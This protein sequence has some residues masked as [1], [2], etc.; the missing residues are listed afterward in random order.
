MLKRGVFKSVFQT[1][2]TMITGRGRIDEELF[3]AFEEALLAADVSVRTADRVLA[4]LRAYVRDNRL[5]DGEQVRSRFKQSLVAA[6]GEPG[7]T[8][9]RFA[10]TSPSLF[11]MVGVNGVGKTTTLGKLAHQ[12]VQEGKK[13]IL[14]AG[15]TFRAAAA[16]QLAIW[17][18]RAGADFI[19]QHERSDPAAVVFDAVQAAKSRG[20]DLIL[21]DTAGRL[22]TKNNLMEELRKIGRVSERELG[23]KPDEILLAL[24]A[25]TGQ[26]AIRQAKEFISAVGVTGIALAKLDGTARGGIV[27]TIREELGLPIKLVG[28]GEGIDDLLPFDPELFVE[29]MLSTE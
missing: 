15:D 3:E 18:E 27:I 6:L 10:D 16:D 29:A 5:I 17:A 25:T 13:V 19:R 7:E 8:A 9:L 2:D 4:D 26:N 23:R 1:L 12:Q 22:H 20:S 21:V 11:L 24:D 28:V 14:A